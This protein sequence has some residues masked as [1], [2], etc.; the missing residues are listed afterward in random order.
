MDIL[1]ARIITTRPLLVHD[2]LFYLL[3]L[4][5]HHINTSNIVCHHQQHCFSFFYFY[6]HQLDINCDIHYNTNPND[7]YRP[8]NKHS[9]PH[10]FFRS[11]YEK[12]A[13]P[14][15]GADVADILCF[16]H[17][18]VVHPHP[19][20]THR[21]NRSDRQQFPPGQASLQ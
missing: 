7:R 13:A 20:Q 9:K 14:S 21:A 11:I 19:C 6:A 5:S 18:S 12:I 17:C 3:I 15:Q 1:A 10:I 8:F 16:A 2:Y 4:S